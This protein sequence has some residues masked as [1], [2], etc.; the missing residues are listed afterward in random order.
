MSPLSLRYLRVG[1]FNRSDLPAYHG[2]LLMVASVK[3]GQPIPIV[4][5]QSDGSLIREFD[6][7]ILTV[8]WLQFLTRESGLKVLTLTLTLGLTNPRI[9][10]PSYYQYITPIPIGRYGNSMPQPSVVT[11]CG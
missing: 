4:G 3:P 5:R 9:I 6:N 8:M 10:E 11:S 1:N 2:L 7:P